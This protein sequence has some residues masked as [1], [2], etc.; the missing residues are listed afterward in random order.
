M[1]W[2]WRWWRRNGRE[3]ERAR[4]EAE[5]RLRAARRLTPVVEGLA[6]QLAN[7]PPDEF[8]ELVAQAFR[9]AP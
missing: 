5:A 9:R 8:A 4:A 3:A 7:L 1:K 2:R 6:D